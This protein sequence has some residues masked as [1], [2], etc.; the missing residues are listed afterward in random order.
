[1]KNRS[2]KIILI[3]ICIAGYV[4][5]SFL[6]DYV[7]MTSY[8][9]TEF[10]QVYREDFIFAVITG[11]LVLIIGYC[12]PREKMISRIL[13]AIAVFMIVFSI[14]ILIVL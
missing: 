13:K 2:M 14:I 1:M 4:I 5:L 11:I 6:A 8:A 10:S 12:L 7:R 3:I 9:A